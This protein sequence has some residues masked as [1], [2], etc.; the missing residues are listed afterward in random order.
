MHSRKVRMITSFAFLASLLW[1]FA[2]GWSIK[3]YLFG[4]T[5]QSSVQQDTEQAAEASNELKIIA[6]GDSLTRG[7]G[8]IEGKGYVGYV[9]DQLKQAGTEVSLI[10]LGIKGLTSSLLVEQMKQKEIERQIGQADIILMTIGGND[11]FLGGQSLTDLSEASISGLEEA[12]FIHLKT[13]LTNIRAVNTEAAV[14]LLGLYNPFSEF[15]NG[16]LMST[17]VRN[18][19]SKTAETLAQYSKAIFVPTYD[20]FQLNAEK[21]LFTDH[22]HP[23]ETGYRLMAERV[24]AL[25][26]E[27]GGQP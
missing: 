9:S 14:Y 2:L 19:N 24:A 1:I 3:D 26:A 11:L 16:E 5:S 15:Q 23:N 6:L 12:Y 17:V 21:L 7:T 13:I 20:L 18:W 8:D 10:N 25:V 27:A 22:F 4:A